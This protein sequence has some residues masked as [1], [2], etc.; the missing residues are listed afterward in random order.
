MK[1]DGWRRSKV[2]IATAGAAI[3]SVGGLV[4]LTVTGVLQSLPPWAAVL[5]VVLELLAP[6]IVYVAVSRSEHKR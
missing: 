1:D 5:I 3:G 4:A 2:E 6:V